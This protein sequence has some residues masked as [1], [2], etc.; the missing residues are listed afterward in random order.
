[1]HPAREFQCE[2]APPGAPLPSPLPKPASDDDPVAAFVRR[3]QLGLWR[4]LRVLGCGGNEAEELAQDA[5]LIA[6]RRG[7]DAEPDAAVR[8]FLRTTARHLWLRRRRDDRRRAERHAAAA[9]RLWQQEAAHDDG[10][11]WLAALDACLQLP[12]R[13]RHVLERTYRDDA[14]RRELAAELG[15]GE[16][17]VRTLLQRL[18]AALRDCIE[19]RRTP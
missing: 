15:I 8:P 13:S 16:H 7:F 2:P 17:G 11:G 10:A 14:G 19:R 12:P 6:L 18:R 5:L 9:E 3:H 1:L 4:F